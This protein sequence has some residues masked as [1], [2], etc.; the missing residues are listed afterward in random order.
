[1]G[2]FNQ[3]EKARLRLRFALVL[4]RLHRA[5]VPR[6]LSPAARRRTLSR[7][8]DY[9]LYGQFP[10]HGG[11]GGPRP[12]FVDHL[13][14]HCAVAHLLARNHSFELVGEIATRRNYARIPEMVSIPGLITALTGLGVTAEEATE[15]QP[16]YPSPF[17]SPCFIVF[18]LQLLA[19]ALT[20]GPVLLYLRLL[21]GY[22]Q[23]DKHG[24]LQRRA[25]AGRELLA[26]FATGFVLA[27]LTFPK[28]NPFQQ[29]RGCGYVW[30]Y[31][32]WQEASADRLVGGIEM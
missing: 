18:G 8:R 6:G 19:L 21:P 10:R 29:G 16:G 32:S 24:R 4:A 28:L 26:M 12:V 27:V 22:E 23:R 31:E 2:L 9:A 25:N 7:L 1:M 15:I 13:G 11:T 20:A 14:T 3:A 5:P 17:P 30:S